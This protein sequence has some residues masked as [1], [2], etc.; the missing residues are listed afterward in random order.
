MFGETC[1]VSLE[2]SFKLLEKQRTVLEVTLRGYNEA[3]DKMYQ[4]FVYPTRSIDENGYINA[5]F[6]K[7][8]T[9]QKKQYRGNSVRECRC[10]AQ[11]IIEVATKLYI[12]TK[13]YINLNQKFEKE[14]CFLLTPKGLEKIQTHYIYSIN[15]INS[16]NDILY[17]YILN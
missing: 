12:N 8:Y 10:Q 9:L 16:S 6:W 13:F 14:G 5:E 4:L 11:R 7:F 17:K 3:F 1:V 15:L 2:D